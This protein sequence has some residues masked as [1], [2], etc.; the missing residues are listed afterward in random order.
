MLHHVTLVLLSSWI[1]DLM[2]SDSPFRAIV[3]PCGN[4]LSHL[5]TEVHNLGTP[6]PLC[7]PYEEPQ[8]QAVLVQRYPQIVSTAEIAQKALIA[9]RMVHFTPREQPPLP[10]GS[11]KPARSSEEIQASC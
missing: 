3:S 11:E 5:Q 1:I 4:L 8:E 6:K 2:H 7:P 10:K 9:C